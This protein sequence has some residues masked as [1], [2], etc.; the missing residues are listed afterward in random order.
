MSLRFGKAAAWMVVGCLVVYLFG[1]SRVGAIVEEVSMFPVR[2]AVGGVVG[3]SLSAGGLVTGWGKSARRADLLEKEN[4]LL[5]VKVAELQEA[6]RENDSLRR[7]L[8][9]RE[10]TGGK[11]MFCRV[12]GRN[13]SQWFHTLTIDLGTRDGV[14]ERTVLTDGRGVVG[15]IYRANYFTSNVLI[16]TGREGGLFSGVGA[17]VERTGDIGV[18]EGDNG[19]ELRLAYLQPET[20]VRAGDSV[21]TSGLG[22][23]FPAGLPIGIVRSV[24]L[25]QDGLS[26]SA[27]VLPSA[28]LSHL[29]LLLALLPE[30]SE[31]R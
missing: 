16:L 3:L 4:A 25:D 14:N 10:R 31:G 21:L 7:L 27:V 5:R 15:R 26:K 19:R 12:V 17:K 23:V 24:V 18:V 22:G 29:N 6:A 30:G 20:Q 2:T 8:R 11:A 9:A 1:R 13:P 28:D